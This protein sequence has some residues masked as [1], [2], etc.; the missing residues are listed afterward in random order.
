[1]Q[2][3]DLKGLFLDEDFILNYKQYNLSTNEAMF[4]IQLVYLSKNG[5]IEFDSKLFSTNMGISENKLMEK[6]E[7][8]Y[9][10]K[11][12]I[13][14][15]KN[16]LVFKI[17]SNDKNYFTIK[18]LVAFVEKI[19][20]RVMTSKEL[21]L[22]ASWHSNRYLKSEIVEAFNISKNINYVNGILNNKFDIP[23]FS[24]NNEDDILNYDWLN[25]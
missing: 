18:E 23:N 24:K 17:K 19:I 6:L 25:S 15:S 10:K 21:D 8:L 1:M 11:I 12:I 2:Y 22:V 13:I 9:K 14:N 20:M 3:L 16:K 7:K 4:Y 5:N